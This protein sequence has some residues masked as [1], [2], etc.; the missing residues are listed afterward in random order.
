MKS[1]FVTKVVSFE[2]S[3]ADELQGADSETHYSIAFR[4]LNGMRIWILFKIE[5]QN[6]LSCITQRSRRLNLSVFHN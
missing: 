6:R 4:N 2:R 5:G 1:L 3:T